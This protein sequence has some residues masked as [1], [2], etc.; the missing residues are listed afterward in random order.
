MGRLDYRTPEA[1]VYRR[2]YNTARWRAIRAA[3][4]RRKPL[5][6]WCAD[7]GRT[8]L[9]SVC[10]HSVNHKGDVSIFYGGPFTSLCKPCHDAGAQRR[11]HLGY[12]GEVDPTGWPADPNH[13]SNRR[14]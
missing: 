8:V 11:D 10:D 13:P 7:L 4:L 12:S 1:E 6:E 9:A 5:C 2:L 3:Q 14:G